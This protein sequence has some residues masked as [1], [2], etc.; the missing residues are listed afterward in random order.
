M[1]NL[2]RV[3]FIII[4]VVLVAGEIKAVLVARASVGP[5][6]VLQEAMGRVEKNELN[7]RIVVTTNDELG[8]LSERFNSMTDGLRQGER[9]REL[10]G[11]YVSSE[12]AHAAVETVDGRG[13]ELAN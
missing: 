3:Q 8:Y 10:F 13:G 9:L 12:V 2:F 4:T 1:T 5:L 7:T 11:L 6:Q